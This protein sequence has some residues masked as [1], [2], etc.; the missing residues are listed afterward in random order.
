MTTIRRK[1][2]FSRRPDKTVALSVVNDPAPPS[3]SVRVPRI[4]KLM[5]LAIHF[6]Q[7]IREGRV[8][9]QSELARLVHVT[10]PRLTQ[11]M[12]LNHLA[13]DVQEQLLHLPA[14]ERGRESIHERNLRPVAACICWTRQR[15]LWKKLQ[16]PAK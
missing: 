6:D 11:I 7:L 9:N 2:S 10:Q 16:S 15:H 5:A 14:V 12:N 8:A 13:P 3:R 4:A 1:I